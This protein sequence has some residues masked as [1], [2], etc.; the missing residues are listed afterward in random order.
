MQAPRPSPLRV[1]RAA[2]IPEPSAEQHPWLIEPLWTS[3]AVGL[4]GGAPKS[5]KTWLALELAVAVGSGCRCLGHFA[6]GRPG[7]VLP[8]K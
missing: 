8:A 7:T 6:V 1:V 5:G 4:I 2:Q 3:G